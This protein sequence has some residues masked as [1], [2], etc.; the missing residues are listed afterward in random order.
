MAKATK[1]V[2]EGSEVTDKT[3]TGSVPF[4]FLFLL[5]SHLSHA[6][7]IDHGDVQTVQFPSAVRP[8]PRSV[9]RWHVVNSPLPSVQTYHESTN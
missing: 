4:L 2:V 3:R 5:F 7:Y 9:C 6:T 8:R 1:G